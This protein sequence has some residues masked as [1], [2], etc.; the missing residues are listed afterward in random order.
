MFIFSYIIIR[1]ESGE[2]TLVKKFKKYNDVKNNDVELCREKI[3]DKEKVAE[4]LKNLPEEEYIINLS[5]VFQALSD[6]T[7]IKIVALLQQQELCVCSIA[8]AIGSTNS[9]ISHQLRIL[10]NLKLLKFRR[11]GKK[12][13]YSLDDKHVKQLVEVAFEHVSE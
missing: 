8:S 3:I 13:Y 12:V 9:N 2:L 4:A 6:P 5:L 7:R 1:I 10:R 11:E